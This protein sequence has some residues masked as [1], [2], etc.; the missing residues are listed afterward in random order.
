MS[1]S[2]LSLQCRF[3]SAK[4]LSWL[5]PLVRRPESVREAEGRA[6][7]EK[8]GAEKKPPLFT[9]APL[10]P[11]IVSKRTARRVPYFEI[12]EASDLEKREMK[13]I[14]KIVGKEIRDLCRYG[15]CGWR[16]ARAF[17]SPALCVELKA[18]TLPGESEC[19][20]SQREPRRLRGLH[21]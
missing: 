20:A 11:E 6:P 14:K 3:A 16:E 2:G 5:S 15:A 10:N 7:S 1:S 18:K 21:G 8:D 9:D 4:M 13:E 12:R 19:L 17:S